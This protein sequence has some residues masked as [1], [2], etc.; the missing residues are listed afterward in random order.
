LS[1]ENGREE[2]VE[3]SNKKF[4]PG[5]LKLLVAKEPFGRA[6]R[7]SELNS[8]DVLGEIGVIAS[9]RIQ[10]LI[11][12]KQYG[13]A[14]FIF[15]ECYCPILEDPE[16][17]CVKNDR[18]KL[19]DTNPKTRA[20]LRWVAEKIDE[21]GRQMEAE[22]SKER[23]LQNLKLSD[24]FNKILN[25]WKNQ[26]M[27]KLLSDVLGGSGSGDTSGG[28]GTGGTGGGTGGS[29]KTKGRRGGDGSGAG[30][31]SGDE[32]KKGTRHPIVLL[33]SFNPDPFGEGEP[34]HLSSRHNPV[35]Q[36]PK[37][38]ETGVY[39][40]NTSRPLATEIIKRYGAESPRWREYHFQR[41]V[42][43]ITMEA[44]HAMNKK[45]MDLTFDLVENKINEVIKSVHDNALE[46]LGQFLL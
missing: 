16:D 38:V 28:T 32:G 24:E 34:L 25:T 31:G 29:S 23:K 10:E 42:D 13:Q 6:G 3:L 30:G 45:G 46:K 11:H 26:F 22:E 27:E 39:W 41:F 14:E 4:S 7:L 12:I 43:I 37:D 9:Y 1:R 2:E 17:D 40:I 19:I 20:L 36:R 21:V 33:S 18:E 15:G 8:I 35:Y 5:H 44:L